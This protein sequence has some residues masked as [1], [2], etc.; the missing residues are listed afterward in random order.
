MRNTKLTPLLTS[1]LIR[2]YYIK[3]LQAM[4]DLAKDHPNTYHS[5][6]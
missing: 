3:E 1:T 5:V 4:K 6:Y 2:N